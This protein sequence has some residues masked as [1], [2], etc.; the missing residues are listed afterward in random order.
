MDRVAQLSSQQRMELF[1]ETA[2]RLG[3]TPFI[4]EKDFWVCWTLKQMFQ[5]EVLSK[6]LMFKGGTSL[7]KV[8]N[9]ITRF[10][11]D[12]DLVLDWNV[13]C[14]DEDPLK[15]RSKTKQAALNKAINSEAIRYIADDLLGR[16]NQ[17]TQPVCECRL[18]SDD[19]FV[20]NVHYPAAFSDE[21]LRPVVRLEIGPLASWLPYSRHSIR[22]YSSEAFPDVFDERECFVNTIVAER[23]FWEKATILHCEAHRPVGNQQPPRYSRHYYDLAM[24]AKNKVKENAL[25]DLEMLGTVV[26]F[27]K[28]FYD[29]GWAEYDLA[30]PGSFR[31]IPDGH[32]MMGLRKDYADMRQMIFGDYPSFDDVIDTLSKLEL[33]I[34]GLGR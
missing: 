27:K 21:Y 24:M 29:R 7:S 31:L 26:A 3:M 33:E 15:S 34:N 17:L 20:I 9:L 14:G 30:K 12:I 5:D 13:V 4:A 16:F 32:V 1:N 2:A 28:H 11:E 22:P 8:F 18:D 10:S 6:Q 23:T 19:G 25:L